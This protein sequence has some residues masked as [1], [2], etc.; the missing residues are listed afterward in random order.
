MP[1]LATAAVRHSSGSETTVTLRTRAEAQSF[2][3][4]IAR[5][6]VGVPSREAFTLLDRGELA[7]TVAESELKMLRALLGK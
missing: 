5:A 3:D 7:G 4:R 1:Q 6:L 2:A